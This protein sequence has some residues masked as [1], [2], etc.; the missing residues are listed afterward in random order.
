MKLRRIYLILLPLL[1]LTMAAGL[2]FGSA[3]LSLSE[4]VSGAGVSRTILL[5][6]RL[7]RVLAGLL[8][9]I[10]LSC[11]GVLLQTVTSNDLASPNIIGINSGAGLAVILLLTLAPKAGAWLP[12]GAF[13]GAFGAALV[14]LAA[15]SRLGSSR[16]GILLIGIAITTL[17]NAAISF[18]SLLDEGI[19]AQ[20]NHFTVGSLR[21]IRLGDLLVPGIL[22]FVSFCAAMA[23]SGRLSV[24]SLGDAAA[25]ALGVRVKGLRIAAMACAA[26]CAAAVVSFAGV[27]GFV[28]L[29]VPHIARALTGEKP[30]RLLPAAALSGGILVILAD[31][32][33]R[34]LFAPSELPVGILMS[35]I[36]APY[37]LILLI[38]RKHHAGN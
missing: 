33:G 10:G 5:G 26:A 15:G 4:L 32:L 34:T 6:I 21:A 38:R 19:L 25:S 24:L 13:C 22:I 12:M 20:Y 11:A 29:V 36:G 23:L 1:M 8:A 30:A 16:S 2:C 31:L 27:L 17:F 3:P 7:P 37:F 28:G 35:L 14:I 18:L 9:G